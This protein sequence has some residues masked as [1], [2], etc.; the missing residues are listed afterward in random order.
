MQL[1]NLKLWINNFKENNTGNINGFCQNTHFPLFPLEI[2]TV[3][4]VPI[5]EWNCKVA[6]YRYSLNLKSCSQ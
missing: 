2:Y 5:I 4:R 3:T 6:F 1:T